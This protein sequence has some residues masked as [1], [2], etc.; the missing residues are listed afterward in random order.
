MT[1]ESIDALLFDL[2]GVLIDIDFDRAFARWGELAGV[3]PAALKQRFDHGTPYQRHERGEIDASAYF[4]ALRTALGIDLGDA[5]FA[6][7]WDRIFGPAIAPTVALLPRLAPRIPLYVLSNTNATH[8]AY[9]G[10]RYAAALA[11]ARRQFLSCEMG[12]RKPDR[13]AFEAVSNAIGV[14]LGRIL[15]FDDTELNVEG[16]RA[17]GMPT[18]WVRAPTDVERAVAPWLDDSRYAA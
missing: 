3:D 18:V 14:P 10:S 17:A 7:G 11:P 12:L 1:P 5:D 2:G 13:E 4:Q 15:F 16:A 8:H 9:W 6:D